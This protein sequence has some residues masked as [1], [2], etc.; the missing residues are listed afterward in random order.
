MIF[1]V[2][3]QSIQII[4][5]IGYVYNIGPNTVKGFLYKIVTFKLLKCKKKPVVQMIMNKQASCSSVHLMSMLKSQCWSNCSFTA[6]L[7]RITVGWSFVSSRVNSQRLVS[8]SCNTN[9]LLVIHI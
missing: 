1:S 7:H 5:C 6:T 3:Q 9:L 2:L 4:M 8:Y